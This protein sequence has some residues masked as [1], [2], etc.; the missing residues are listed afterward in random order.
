LQ[1]FSVSLSLP[2]RIIHEDPSV[3]FAHIRTLAMQAAEKLALVPGNGT[4]LVFDRS[5]RDGREHLY[6]PLLADERDELPLIWSSLTGMSPKACKVTT[7]TGSKDFWSGNGDSVLRKNLLRVVAYAYHPLPPPYAASMSL[8]DRTFAAS[9]PF[10]PIL[11]EVGRL[12]HLKS[13]PQRRRRMSDEMRARERRCAYCQGFIP[14]E[15]RADAIY[16]TPS[17]NQL[18]Y[19]ARKKA[20]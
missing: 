4:L 20:Q 12:L 19:V 17:C 3:K 6:G 16:C 9:G 8:L 13:R 10:E 18:A 15:K 2:D 7:V 5:P 1:V 11:A 14:A